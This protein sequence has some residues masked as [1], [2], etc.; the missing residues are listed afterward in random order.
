FPGLVPFTAEQR[1]CFRG[2]D[3]LVESLVQQLD[4]RPVLA[5][6]GDSGAGKS[7]LVEA[8]VLPRLRER[9][10]ELGSTRLEPGEHPLA[11]L[12]QQLGELGSTPTWVLH[13]D[14]FEQSFTL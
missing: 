11:R 7:S 6:V 2:R 9:S 13:V 3:A 12:E 5:V 4:G 14:Q 10:P 1:A 8:G